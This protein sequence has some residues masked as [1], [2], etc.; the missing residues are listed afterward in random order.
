M[1]KTLRETLSVDRERFDQLKAELDADK[2]ALRR[3]A[4]NEL[5]ADAVAFR[6]LAIAALADE[7]SL[8]TRSRLERIVALA[9]QDVGEYRNLYTALGTLNSKSQLSSLRALMPTDEQSVV[10]RRLERLE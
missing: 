2:F 4:F 3:R 7:L 6:G 9:D 1:P 5:A 8:E 10:D